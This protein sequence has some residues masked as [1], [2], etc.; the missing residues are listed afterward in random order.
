LAPSQEALLGATTGADERESGAGPERIQ[1]RYASRHPAMPRSS[2][3]WLILGTVA[4]SAALAWLTL[5]R[6]GPGSGA[7]SSFQHHALAP[8]HEL[9][10]GGAADVIL[11]QGGVEAIDVDPARRTVVEATVADGRLLIRARDRRRWWNRLFGRRTIEQSTI[12]VHL[13][14]L[15]KLA[16]TGNV[17]VTVAG[18]KTDKLRIGASG[19]AT[20]TIGDLQATTLRVDGS[21]ALKADVA[22][23]V[24]DEHVSIS[25][26]GTYRAER[27]LATDATVSVSGV[28]N[29]VVNAERKLRASI[30]GAGLIEYVGN[31]EVIEQVSG[32][33]RVRRRDSSATPGMRVADDVRLVASRKM[34]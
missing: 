32:I 9:E 16:L 7:P 24:D 1:C 8:F 14:T 18:L 5:T 31:P 28:G 19:G 27:L 23:R 20:L 3:P 2:L 11:V 10:I 25:G 29:V 12:T 15:D 4:V 6:G 33:G 26:A 34:A 30:S 21:G 13:R 22:G 17:K